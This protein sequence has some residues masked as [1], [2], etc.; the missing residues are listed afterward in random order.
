MAKIGWQLSSPLFSILDSLFSPVA[1][2][3][4]SCYSL[5]RKAPP[6]PFRIGGR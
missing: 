4:D 6:G 5:G 2:R 3:R 1:L